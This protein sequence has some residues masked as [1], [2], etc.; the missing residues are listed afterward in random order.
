MITDEDERDGKP[1]PILTEEQISVESRLY[2]ILVE[3]TAAGKLRWK[4]VDVHAYYIDF[5]KFR[6]NI[7]HPSF[8]MPSRSRV[9]VQEEDRFLTGFF[10]PDFQLFRL[11]EFHCEQ[12][13][14]LLA[15]II[16]ALDNL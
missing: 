5:G 9:S 12:R 4:M 7:T 8:E 2:N 13:Q 1:L 3:K 11:A 6:V 10:A 14:Q 15:Q 16:K